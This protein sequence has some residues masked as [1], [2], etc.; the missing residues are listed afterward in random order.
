M[1]KLAIIVYASALVLTASLQAAD[2]LPDFLKKVQLHNFGGY[3]LTPDGTG[4]S[5]YRL[6][7]EVREHMS[8]AGARIMV[9]SQSG[10]I[11]FVLN[12]GAKLE[13]VTIRLKSNRTTQINF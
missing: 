11:R 7:S 3:E 8:E 12:E 5:V 2:N 13:D 9:F 1:I 6:P 4:V 10:E